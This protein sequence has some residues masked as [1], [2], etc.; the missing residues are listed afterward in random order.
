[1]ARYPSVDVA[2]DALQARNAEL[3]RDL[4]A[5]R[6]GGDVEAALDRVWTRALDVQHSDETLGVAVAMFDALRG[7]GL[8]VVQISL[9]G[10]PDRDAGEAPAWTAGVDADGAARANQHVTATTGLALLDA[11]FAK[12]QA[13]SPPLSET[14]APAAFKAYLR[15]S[16]ARYPSS[17]ADRV[18]AR[19]PRAATYHYIA[20]PA[21]ARQ[22]GPLVAVFSE[23]P[24]PDALRTLERFA[25]LFALAYA[26]HQDLQQAEIRA[27]TSRLDAAA[28]RARARAL[29]MRGPEDLDDAVGT[30]VRELRRLGVPFHRCTVAAFDGP[31]R[32]ARYWSS[33]GH[34]ATP[35]ATST[36][37]GHP[38]Y[39]A[40]WVAWRT[41]QDLSYILEGDSLDA[42]LDRLRALDPALADVHD[43]AE[44]EYVY[45]VTV[46]AGVLAAFSAQPFSEDTVQAMQ[47]MGGAF[48]A[49]YA[50]YLDL[51]EDH[52]RAR[53][54][55]L[56]A[57][58]D[59]VRAEVA[60]MRTADDLDRVT[61]RVWT[62][63]TDLGV[64]FVQCG[65][66]IVDEPAGAVRALLAT[67][68]GA[69]LGALE[70][71]ADEPPLIADVVAHWRRQ[72]TLAVVLPPD[73]VLAWAALL[74][75]G[76]L[77]GSALPAGPLAL[78]FAPFA[79]GLLYVGSP[80]PLSEEDGAAV[81]TL[82]SA[83]EVAYARYADFQ[84]LD[85]RTHE[86]EAALADLQAAQQ[87][88]VQSEKLASLGQ[89][90]AGIAHEIKN[91]LNFVNNFASLSRELAAE[92]AAEVEGDSDPTLVRE[93]VDDLTDN[94][95][96][97]E[98][99]GRRAD[100]IVRAMM[101]HARSGAGERGAL[102][103]DALVDEHV[104]LAYHGRRAQA[105]DFNVALVR[106]LG[107]VGLVEGVAQDLGRV[108]INLVSNAFDAVTA[109]AAAE[110]RAFEP[111]VRIATATVDGGVEIRVED[112]GAG[113]SDEV[114]ARVFEPFFT[115]KPAGKGTGL[116]LS[117]SHDIVEQ[118]HGGRL[119]V[120]SS[121][122]GTTFVVT[123]PAAP[124]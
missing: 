58:V 37:E 77:D 69:P 28:E 91:P 7:L 39:D 92:L 45:A 113:M 14:L 10:R 99:H 8:P 98:Q 102:D 87:R 56:A 42:Y 15:A 1:M 43:P 75:D 94:A 114:R 107:G 18:V 66:F 101:Q 38:F 105:S 2:L 47:R 106:E 25:V 80:A 31:T 5:A 104:N 120:E 97:I 30:V 23:P 64:P 67:P 20:V 83:F 112:N 68:D 96:R 62:E 19:A 82:A 71:P 26:R 48:D 90:T 103:L 81:Q 51:L 63:L 9:S 53:E 65:V 57:S 86:L 35:S 12:A 115:T 60:S 54:A 29:A 70:L 34:A 41:Q 121:D 40:L 21:R 85:A 110:G 73:R 59:R 13:G 117:M 123:L 118:G 109:R 50:R 4:A 100:A 46:P 111:T 27:R 32:S 76:G 119:A 36:V 84:R 88:L 24:G 93:L 52:K 74:A 79:Q 44:R 78:R 55:A 108:V 3:E 122:A 16:L 89:L 33:T 11:T 116:G 61:P 49:A 95:R 124:A 72:D 17:Y 6:R 22:S